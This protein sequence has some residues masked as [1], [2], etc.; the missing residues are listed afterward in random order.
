MW[1][2]YRGCC[3]QEHCANMDWGRY[4]RR[5]WSWRS[6]SRKL[7]RIESQALSDTIVIGYSRCLE[8]F[9]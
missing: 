2:L 9:G 7:L 3:D 1:C 6:L 5:V 4:A 8:Y